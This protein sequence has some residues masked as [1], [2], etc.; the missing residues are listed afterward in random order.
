MKKG[1]PST[2]FVKN[3]NPMSDRIRLRAKEG[4]DVTSKAFVEFMR[5]AF[6]ASRK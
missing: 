1:M 3:R 2:V 5:D 4:F 6:K